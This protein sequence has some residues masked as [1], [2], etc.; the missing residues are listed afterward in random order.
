[1]GGDCTGGPEYMKDNGKRKP[2][3]KKIPLVVYLC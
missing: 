1:M 3:F 2:F